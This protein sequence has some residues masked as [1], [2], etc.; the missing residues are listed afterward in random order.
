MRLLASSACL[1]GGALA[2]LSQPWIAGN[3]ASVLIDEEARALGLRAAFGLLAALLWVQALLAALNHWI[4][5][6][7]YAEAVFDLRCQLYRHLQWQRF[8]SHGQRARSEVVT[9]I[10]RDA[11][12]VAQF[13]SS[14]LVGVLPAL[15]TL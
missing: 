5:S 7:L 10:E 12:G 8:E 9:L 3:I 2:A 14:T 1:L 15:I 4:L 13:L 6:K 11:H